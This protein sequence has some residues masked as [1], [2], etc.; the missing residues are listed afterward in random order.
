MPD[1]KG[2]L[3]DLPSSGRPNF[4]SLREEWYPGVQLFWGGSTSA[5]IFDAILGIRAIVI[6]ATA[7]VSATGAMSI[8]RDGHESW[9]WLVPDKGEPAHGDFVWACAPE[10]RAA[11]HVC[12]DR[13]H[14][15]VNGGANKVNHWSL[16]IRIVNSQ[17]RDIID[18]F[19][20]WQVAATARIVRHCWWKYPN[21]KQVVSHAVLDPERRTDPGSHFPWETFRNLVIDGESETMPAVIAKAIPMVDLPSPETRRITCCS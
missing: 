5:R 6:H 13:L 10:A 1:P 19:S 4:A 8:M 15:A 18:P 2:Y 16:G 11:A 9:H 12:N 3:F 14:P 20:E 17:R 21:L 7:G